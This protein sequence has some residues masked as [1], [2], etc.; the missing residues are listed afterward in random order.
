MKTIVVGG[1]KG[2]AVFSADL[3]Y[4]YALSRALESPS[5]GSNICQFIMLN[6]S[7]ADADVDDPTVRRC[8]DYARRWGH[9]GVVITNLFALCA[10]DPRELRLADDPVGDHNE[11]FVLRT[12]THSDVRRVVCAW[13]AHGAHANAGDSMRTQLRVHGVAPC[14]LRITKS[15]QPAHPLYL[16]LH[17]EPAPLLDSR[18]THS[19]MLVNP[20]VASEASRSRSGGRARPRP[21]AGAGCPRA[22]PRSG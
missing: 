9:T 6:P 1:R 18:R 20:F 21:R 14:A 5:V 22:A 11:E 17:L 15:G 7:T 12:A 10:K 19:L 8:V 16:P 4:R 13:G 2:Q 3:R